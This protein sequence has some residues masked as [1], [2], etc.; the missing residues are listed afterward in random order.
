MTVN[1]CTVVTS[2]STI[3]ISNKII[4]PIHRRRRN[5]YNNNFLLR[6][7]IVLCLLTAQQ[8]H[9]F[10]GGVVP[11]ITFV[12]PQRQH[13]QKLRK[14]SYYFWNRP[15]NFYSNDPSNNKFIITK[16]KIKTL[17][18]A[19]DDEEEY[20]YNAATDDTIINP[21]DNI[22]LL[23]DAVDIADPAS[24][25]A[26]NTPSP[27]DFIFVDE[28]FER[29]LF[30]PED[31]D[32]EERKR[33]YGTSNIQKVF[34]NPPTLKEWED[35]STTTTATSP[36]PTQKKKHEVMDQLILCQQQYN[37][38][39][40]QFYKILQKYN[41]L[42]QVKKYYNGML[43]EY[44]KLSKEFT[45]LEQ[46]VTTI[47]SQ[48]Q[49]VKIYNTTT[50]NSDGSDVEAKLRFL[51]ETL[52]KQI[53]NKIHYIEMPIEEWPTKR[54]LDGFFDVD[55]VLFSMK[56]DEDIRRF[57]LSKAT[58]IYDDVDFDNN[59]R[60]FI[61]DYQFDLVNL[62]LASIQLSPDSYA[63]PTHWIRAI[64][65]QNK[66]ANFREE[67]LLNRGFNWSSIPA[68]EEN[69]NNIPKWWLP[70]EVETANAQELKEYWMLFGG[71]DTVP[72][73]SREV[74]MQQQ[75]MDGVVDL[76]QEEL[77]FEEE[78]ILAWQKWMEEVYDE[79]DD[80]MLEDEM[81]EE[82]AFIDEKKVDPWVR[83]VAAF[84]KEFKQESDEFKRAIYN[85]EEYELWPEEE[86]DDAF[87]GHLVLACSPSEEDM[88]LSVKI[89][90]RMEQ[91]FGKQVFVET[92]VYGHAKP[93]DNV[94]EIWLESWDIDL[95]HSKRRATFDREWTGP[96]VVDDA[97][98]NDLVEQVRFLISDDARYSFNFNEFDDLVQAE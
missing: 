13:Q 35:K 75:Q 66:Y 34:Y 78:N 5:Y 14:D 53:Q 83:D 88:E 73:R 12:K 16:A 32:E 84:E 92:R 52:H 28:E 61:F 80:I 1:S 9:A 45:G 96:K 55:A 18:D 47:I 41:K 90:R 79:E 26:A 74:E 38:F 36:L 19:E 57:D 31:D 98:L 89:T 39:L 68:D 54:P 62:W 46:N 76:D 91:E 24:S 70:E 4:I 77:T 10:Y 97:T 86:G 48:Y 29:Y 20:Y 23:D 22:V 82:E 95:L 37:Y 49:S 27:D 17:E 33:V 6:E 25:A 65:E 7:M 51:V 64:S 43:A 72:Q 67:Q 93:D 87:R 40:I 21:D 56:D 11:S 44:H 30:P 63:I 81:S 2:T 71:Y 69:I 3:A 8:I 94:Y 60:L 59:R 50:A 58:W 42:L 15:T 85:K